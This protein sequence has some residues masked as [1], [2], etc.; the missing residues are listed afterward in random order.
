MA[1]WLLFTGKVVLQW[2]KQV[3]D[4]G[5]TPRTSQKLLPGAATHVGHVGVVNREAKDPVGGNQLDHNDQI[6]VCVC[7]CG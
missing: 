4:D 2:R 5:N 6:S 1:K 3:P 7:V